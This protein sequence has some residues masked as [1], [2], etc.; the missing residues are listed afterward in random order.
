MDI[1]SRPCSLTIPFLCFRPTKRPARTSSSA[2]GSNDE[3]IPLVRAVFA[4]TGRRATVVIVVGLAGLMFVPA[5][6]DQYVGNIV[7]SLAVTV[8]VL[9]GAGG[10]VFYEEVRS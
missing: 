6:R 4:T 8:V 2:E 1:G 10:L 5:C 7:S 9:L 3:A